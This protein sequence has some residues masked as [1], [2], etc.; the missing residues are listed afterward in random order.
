M[1]A[2][3]FTG[4][5]HS[6]YRMMNFVLFTQQ[7]ADAGNEFFFREIVWEPVDG[8]PSAFHASPPCHLPFGE[9]MDG[10]LKLRAHLVETE[11]ADDVECQIFVFKTIVYQ[12]LRLYSFG[13]QAAHFVDHPRFESS[14]EPFGY[15]SAPFVAWD[16]DSD[17]Q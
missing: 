9:L 16:V 15:P 1:R 14:V 4:M 7:C 3:K 5:L 13:Y 2:K 12:L 10:S 17:Y 6:N 8:E 11:F